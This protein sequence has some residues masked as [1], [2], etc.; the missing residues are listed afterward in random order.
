MK[1][2]TGEIY[3]ITN[4]VNGKIYIGL[5][6]LDRKK[7]EKSKYYGSGKLIKPAIKKHGL[8]NFKREII[9]EV[10]IEQLNEREIFWIKEL[11]SKVPIGYNIVDGGNTTLGYKHSEETKAKMRKR[12]S[13]EETKQKIRLKMF[14]NK[15]GVL[16]VKYKQSRR[17]AGFVM[18]PKTK[19]VQIAINKANAR[20][21]QLKRECKRMD[22]HYLAT[23]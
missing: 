10:P 5:S 19:E 12:K 17:L 21:W 23:I 16:S 3:K 7:F 22:Q 8:Q 1:L 14:G 4:L 6:K 9:E 20:I 15:N 11:N 2:H 13:S 18:K